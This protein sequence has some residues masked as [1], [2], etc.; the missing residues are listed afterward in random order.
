MFK[1]GTFRAHSHR[2]DFGEWSDRSGTIGKW[3]KFAGGNFDA[4][5]GQSE[6]GDQERDVF[7]YSRQYTGHSGFWRVGAN[8]WR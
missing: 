2:S 1:G 8:G 6:S 4:D 5:S 7:V 3:R